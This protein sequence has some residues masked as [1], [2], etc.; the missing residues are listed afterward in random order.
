MTNEETTTEETS[1][2]E[3]PASGGGLA[4]EQIDTIRELCT[5]ALGAASSNLGIILNTEVEIPTIDVVEL[6][7]VSAFSEPFTDSEKLISSLQF[8]GGVNYTTAF[9]LKTKDAKSIAD[10]ML[11]GEG[12]VE[13][14]PL[15]ELQLSAVSEAFSQMM[16]ASATSLASVLSEG[17]DVTAPEIEEYSVES[18]KTR[19]V[20]DADGPIL[21]IRFAL[22]LESGQALEMVQIMKTTE[23]LEQVDKLMAQEAV[24]EEEAPPQA[25]EAP[26]TP[27]AEPMPGLDAAAASVRPS[28]PAP[29]PSAGGGMPP[30]KAPPI[31]PVTVQPV[32]FAAFDQQPEVYGEYNKNLDLVLDVTLNLT[33]QL[34][35]TELSIKQI[36]ELTRGSVIELDRIAGEPVDLLANGKLIAKG[37][38][39]VIE[40]NFGLRITSIVSPED[41]LR[42]LTG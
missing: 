41:R 37:E 33:V 31:D 14:G 17:V 42:G 16:N 35:S 9:V 8:S 25:Q 18:L 13:D 4:S 19:V 22:T 2:P 6:A 30:P 28:A 7:N 29:A 15:E 3:N 12:E 27:A 5:I 23:A 36:L 10:M 40:D 26:S 39:V 24:G 20:G 38:V 1:T 21:S 34:G 32:Q 11:G